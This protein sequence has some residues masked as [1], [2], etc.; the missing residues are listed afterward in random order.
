MLWFG[1]VGYG[2]VS[3][4][5]LYV[6]CI[7]ASTLLWDLGIS[8]HMLPRHEIAMLKNFCISCRGSASAV[9][10][11]GVWLGGW[12]LRENVLAAECELRL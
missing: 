9:L 3:L 11:N 10:A 4:W 8:S 12:L 5:F 6:S 1:F 2:M 7:L